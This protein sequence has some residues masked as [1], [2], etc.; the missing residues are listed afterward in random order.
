MKR[1][2]IIILV[3]LVL[4][5]LGAFFFVAK[6]NQDSLPGGPISTSSEEVV[7][8]NFTGS[9]PVIVGTGAAA[10]AARA[11]ADRAIEEFTARANEEVPALREEFGEEVGASQYSFSIEADTVESDTTRSVVLAEYQYTGGANGMSTYEV[12][13]ESKRTGELLT[14][15]EVIASESH[16]AFVAFVKERLSNWKTEDGEEIYVFEDAVAQLTLDSFKNWSMSNDTFTIYFNKYDVG[17]GALGAVAFPIAI[18][19]MRAV[20][21]EGV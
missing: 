12:F 15:D 4:I 6:K 18:E 2:H 19:D 14:I 1:N 5:A 17:A 11:Y 9:K 10:D 20:L 8:E 7:A 13:T 21:A 16:D 3:V